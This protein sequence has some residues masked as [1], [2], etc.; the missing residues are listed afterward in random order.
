MFS[1]SLFTHEE[2]DG[3][4][5]KPEKWIKRLKKDTGKWVIKQN[6]MFATTVARDLELDISRNK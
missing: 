5:M 4:Y 2:A 3:L 1:L 6:G